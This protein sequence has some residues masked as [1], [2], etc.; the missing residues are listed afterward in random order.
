MT[1]TSTTGVNR[2]T[3]NEAQVL[4]SAEFARFAALTASLIPQEWATDSRC[5]RR[6]GDPPR[7]ARPAPGP[8]RH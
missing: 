4:A 1:T 2:I 5:A 8:P 3:R 7:A 6:P